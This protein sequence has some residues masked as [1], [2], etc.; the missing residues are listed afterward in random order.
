VKYS[1]RSLM[2]AIT[3]GPAAIAGMFFLWPRAYDDFSGIRKYRWDTDQL[4]VLFIVAVA[5]AVV[6]V[7]ALARTTSYGK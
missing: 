5:L 3:L 6:G 4:S 2:I 7:L 1:L